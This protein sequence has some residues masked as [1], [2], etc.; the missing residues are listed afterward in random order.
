MAE[1]TRRTFLK[2]GLAAT[3]ATAVFP[4]LLA[5]RAAGQ[6]APSERIPVACI[7]VGDRGTYLLQTLLGIPEAQVVAVCDVKRDRREAA[8]A[9]VNETYGNTDCAAYNAHED[10]IAGTGFDACTI[11]T[12]DHWHV[13]HAVHAAR[14]GKDIYLEKPL[15][16][17]V[18]QD[19]FLRKVIQETGRVFQF[20]TQQRSDYRFRQACEMALNK[21][22]GDLQTIRVW[23][24]PSIQG[25]SLEQTPVPETLDYARWLGPAPDVP[26]TFERDSNKWWWFNSDYSL[27]FISAWG[28]HPM[29]IALWGAGD[30]C[31]TKVLVEG[32]G[33]Y[34][35]E[36]FCNTATE[37]DLTCRFDSGVFMGYRHGPPPAEW[38][39]R[40]GDVSDH[41]TVFEGTDGWV[42][43]NRRLV[44]SSPAG[45]VEAPLPDDAIRL[46][47]SNHHMQQFLEC[48]RSR[49]QPVSD[50]QSAAEGDIL[51][52]VCDI[53]LRMER[54]LRWDPATEQFE[55]SEEANSRLSV[56]M[57]A[58]WQLA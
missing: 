7:G 49:Q 50:I 6:V 1:T 26:Y 8:Q 34:P 17:S 43:V 13:L 42:H 44:N 55:G 18:E 11:A 40:Y 19:Q 2:S 37:W 32:K 57:R 46:T 58:P 12:C 56:P 53:A 10:L 31:R 35:E 30:L 21:V 14:A 39:A 16:I 28:I 25:G 45:L 15:G 48:V 20:G 51:C 36:G 9:L 41:G 3:A 38:A 4:N 52:H 33:V 5:G 27:G 29:D 22:I 23:A 54:T 24:P 47:E